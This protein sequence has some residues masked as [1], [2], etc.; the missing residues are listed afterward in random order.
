M[1]RALPLLLLLAALALAGREGDA[2][3]ARTPEQ[4]F[5]ARC[6]TCHAASRVGHRMA[7]RD[8]WRE[9]VDRMR[10]MPQSGISPADAQ[11]ILD[12]LVSRRGEAQA[13]PATG[14]RRGGRTAYGPEWLSILETAVVVE[15][16]V[17]LGDVTYEVDRAGD[18]AILFLDGE[19]HPL[20]LPEGKVAART[21]RIDAWKLAG[22]T[23]EIHIVLYEIAG[24]RLRLARALRVAP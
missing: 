10:R 1:L 22:R 4:L 20:S 6:S 14:E 2:R 24:K 21:V 18:A 17:R 7:T 3:A 12:Y 11:V 19:E 16:R 23:Y 15:D 13:P 8:E 9:I 5:R